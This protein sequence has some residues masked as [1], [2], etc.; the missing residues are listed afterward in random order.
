MAFINF[1]PSLFIPPL[2]LA[3]LVS[4]GLSFLLTKAGKVLALDLPGERRLHRKPIPRVGGL[5][6]WVTFV[7]L[8][9][10]FAQLTL[11]VM[12]FL[13]G[14][15]F[16]FLVGLIDDFVQLPAFYKFTSQILGALILVLF[17]ISIHSLTN[18]LGGTFILPF[19]LDLSLTVAWTVTVVNAINFLDGLDGLAG[20]VSFVAALTLGV[21]SLLVFVAQPQTTILSV[22]L[23]GAI[24]GFLFF[25]F[26]PAKIFMGDSGS[27]FLGYT[28]ATLAII[29]GGK[30]A[31]AAL[32]LGVPLIDFFWSFWRR[33]RQGRSP[34]DR[35]LEHLH[36]RL[37][38]SGL[39]QGQVVVVFVFLA[40]FF[41][42]A[43]LLGGTWFKL[44]AFLVI[45]LAVIAVMMLVEHRH[46][47]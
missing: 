9:P 33:I 10:F 23:A 12:G 7:V 28:L 8:L 5:A 42:I 1:S 27:H 20:S 13:V 2:L 15:T 14:L 17:G 4:S 29:S 11:P 24:L 36:H 16:I 6:M 32:V 47:S 19:W 30:I 25:N 35:D 39:T 37:L 3:L 45:I 44:V 18:P 38:K 21:L 26:H 46:S 31:T 40:L 22:I 43:A 34:V 41:G